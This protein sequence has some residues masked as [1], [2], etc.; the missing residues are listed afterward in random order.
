[1]IGVNC[2]VR[3]LIK[4]YFKKNKKIRESSNLARGLRV[5]GAAEGR[6]ALPPAASKGAAAAASKRLAGPQQGYSVS[7]K[8]KSRAELRE[9]ATAAKAAAAGAAAKAKAAKAA[10]KVKK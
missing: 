10:A 5:R 3:S 6:A 7:V 9:G 8:I 2:E 4:K 1:V